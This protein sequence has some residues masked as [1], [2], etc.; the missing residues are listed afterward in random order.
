MKRIQFRLSVVFIGHGLITLNRRILLREIRLDLS[1][2]GVIGSSSNWVP[3]I[4]PCNIYCSSTFYFYL[5][6]VL[7]FD[8]FVLSFSGRGRNFLRFW[9]FTSHQWAHIVSF[10]TCKMEKNVRKKNPNKGNEERKK[11]CSTKLIYFLRF[12]SRFVELY[13]L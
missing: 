2:L 4:V 8:T 5:N 1:S 6:F 12:V 3:F 11:N 7:C 10:F 9:N 13:P